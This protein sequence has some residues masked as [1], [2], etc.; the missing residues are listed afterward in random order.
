[1]QKRA[2]KMPRFSLD[3]TRCGNL[4]EQITAGLRTAIETGYY[5]AGDI[6]PP[7]RDLAGILDVSKGVAEQAVSKI[8]EEGLISPRP[9]VGSVVC[10]K[11]R[12]RWKGVALIVYLGDAIRYEAMVA[13]EVRNMLSDAGY[14][15]LTSMIRNVSG[16]APD[17]S[18]VEAQLCQ[19]V[20]VVVQV[21]GSPK[22]SAWLAAR[23][24]PY[25]SYSRSEPPDG[26][27]NVGF[28]RR[29]W[30]LV[31]D[32]FIA[33]CRARNV[34]SV[35]IIEA[36]ANDDNAVNILKRAAVTARRWRLPRPKQGMDVRSL[37]EIAMNAFKK[38]FASEGHAWLPDVLLFADDYLT[39]GA[40]QALL[41][42]GVRIPEEVS[43]VTWSN[44]WEGPI[45]SKPFTRL[46]MDAVAHG[47]MIADGV[48]EYLANGMFPQ[49]L[50]TKPE[51][52]QGETF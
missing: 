17:F 49:N 46:E 2:F 39:T 51:Y 27:N 8:R 45:Y 12:P 25:V 32:A 24:V 5:R 50:E 7:V 26:G 42:E 43:V 10:A 35:L 33:R 29:R 23:G 11:N 47:R 1:M 3:R 37:C 14:L 9:A 30:N 13:G 15:A 21:A 31:P 6:L 19:H 48:R 41:A 52:I 22:L 18:L 16:D 28:V 38:R 36:W 44:R 20:D 34:K 4:A 40:L